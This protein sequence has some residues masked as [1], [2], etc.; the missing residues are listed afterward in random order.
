MYNTPANFINEQKIWEILEKNKQADFNK[1]RETLS[2]ASEMKGLNLDDVAALTNISDPEMLS[3]LFNTANKVKETIYGKRL[4]I[5]APLYISNLC[6]NEC[7]YCAFRATNK[8]IVRSVLSQKK[9]ANEVKTLI[10]QGQKRVL[11][12]AGES[13]PK[14]GFQYVLDSIKTIYEVKTD[15]GEIRRVNVNVAP[16]KK[17]EF[18]QLKDAGIGTYQIFQE[19]YHR[20][21]YNKVHLAGKKRDYNWRAWSLHRAMEAGIDDVGI[22][23]LFG[24]FDYR[25][26]IMAMMQ[27]IFELEEKF[28]VGPHT[29]SV[30]RLEPATNSDIASHPPFP[31]SDIDFRKIVAILRLAVP[32]TGI[33]MSTR[34]TAKMR[35]E[36][37]ALGVSQISA[38]S[39]TN[40]GGYEEKS[41]DDPSGQFSLG[42]HRPLDEVIRDVASMGYIPSFCTA[43]Y[44][45]GRTGSDFM[46]L[47]KPGD[48]KLHC[49][50][51]ALSSFKEYLQNYA[52]EETNEVGGKLIHKTIN[53]M[54]GLAKQRAE[55]L[56]KRVEAGR[57]DVYC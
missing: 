14:Q 32:Y 7:L 33:I 5:F 45:L 53:D 49:G 9:I 40:P 2:K 39:K 48:I 34:E 31:V 23:V 24:L 16:L 1:I 30:P 41:E 27:H 21:T 26:E 19:T 4:V 15:H 51:N 20:E 28:G 10:N 50:P 22:G 35:R 11:L 13:Y 43:C 6:A 38:G 44:R 54:S 12:V 47:A 36:T 29:V 52:S 25:F 37:F 8:D 18:K 46:D 56:I 17:E 42:D 3:E 55:K 57:D